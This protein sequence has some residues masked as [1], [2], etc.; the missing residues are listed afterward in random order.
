MRSRVF[1][2]SV[3]ASAS[4]DGVIRPRR[5]RS[6]PSSGSLCPTT[7]SRSTPPC[8]WGCDEPVTLTLYILRRDEHERRRDPPAISRIPAP[9]HAKGSLAAFHVPTR[10][11]TEPPIRPQAVF[12]PKCA[13]TMLRP[14]DDPAR[15]AGRKPRVN[16]LTNRSTGCLIRLTCF[17][18]RAGDSSRPP[19]MADQWAAGFAALTSRTGPRGMSLRRP[20]LR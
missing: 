11:D 1:V 8:P 2:C 12:S 18:L 10:D 7:A 4:W 9:Y 17:R 3:R 14:L 19:N 15:T 5:M 13:K 16:P 20:N 6:S